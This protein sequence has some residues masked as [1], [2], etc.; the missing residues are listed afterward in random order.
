MPFQLHNVYFWI[1]RFI[2]Y[3][4]YFVESK[5]VTEIE[6]ADGSSLNILDVRRNRIV[7]T[8]VSAIQPPQLVVAKFDPTSENIGKLT[9]INCTQPL[10][11]PNGENLVYEHTEFEYKTDD[12][13]S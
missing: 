4:I 9:L 1:V 11:I 3:I 2:L 10:D 6:N 8:R 5:V 7:F 13:I 12:P